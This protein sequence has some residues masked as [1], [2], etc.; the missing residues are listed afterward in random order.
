MVDFIESPRFP[1]NISYG[2]TGGP[3]FLTT[4]FEGHSGVEQTA[5][6]WERSKAMY[7]VAQGVRDKTDMDVIQDLFMNT[8]GRAVGFR[9]KDWRDYILTQ[10]VIGT[11]DG[12]N[13]TFRIVRKYVF[14]SNTYTRRIFKPVPTTLDANAPFIVRVDGVVK[15]VTTHYTIDFTTGT[16]VFTA[17]N[18]PG[19]TLLVDVTCWFDI[20]VRF[21][22]DHFTPSHDGFQIESW[23]QIP[24]IEILFD[25][26]A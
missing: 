24:L 22:T 13:N 2:S 9:F 26:P 16:I 4:I 19:N 21:D 11:G 8:R 17:G 1:A 7:Q 5:I 23:N 20:P 12:V 14:G 10:G 6:N 15:T 3:R 25:D 18:I